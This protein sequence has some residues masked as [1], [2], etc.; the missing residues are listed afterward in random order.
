ME[1]RGNIRRVPGGQLPPLNPASTVSSNIHAQAG[2]TQRQS[3]LEWWQVARQTL[4]P[5][6]PLLSRRNVI[7]TRSQLPTCQSPLLTT[8]I[9]S[10]RG[11]CWHST[12]LLANTLANRT[13]RVTEPIIFPAPLSVASARASL[14]V[15]H[16]RATRSH[17]QPKQQQRPPD[18][19]GRAGHEAVPRPKVATMAL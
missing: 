16:H 12:Q 18:K 11:M 7:H 8:T 10:L 5:V 14:Q 6:E 1:L 17:H 19:R 2:L 3:M 15:S 13:G 4:Q 9:L